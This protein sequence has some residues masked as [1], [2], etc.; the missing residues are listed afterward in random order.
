MKT[1]LKAVAGVFALGFA[2]FG[3]SKLIENRKE[4]KI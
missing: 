4:E 3:I 2:I 1:V